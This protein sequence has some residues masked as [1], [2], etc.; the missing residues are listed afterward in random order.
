MAGAVAACR[1]LEALIL[2]GAALLGVLLGLLQRTPP[3]GGGRRLLL[4]LVCSLM[5]LVLLAILAGIGG[6][7]DWTWLFGLALILVP[8]AAL[9]FLLGYTLARWLKRQHPW[10]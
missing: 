5:F 9:L 3:H 6:Q 2:P 8:V 10:R 4:A 7:E 1:V